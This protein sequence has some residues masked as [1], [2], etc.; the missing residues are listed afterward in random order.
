VC[1]IG[2]GDSTKTTVLDAIEFALAPRWSIPFSDADFYQAK[3][4]NP[5]CIEVTV[6][7]LPEELI[8]EDRYGLYLRG[9]RDNEPIHD[10][11]ED[12]WEPVITVCL[13]VG[14]DLE[15]RWEV[16][17]D[18][19]PDAKPIPWRDRERL[20]IARLGADVEKH[21]T[22]SRGSALSRITGDQTGTGATLA[23]ANRAAHEAIANASLVDLQ[24]A[25]EVA[26]KAALEFG[27]KFP[28]L[29]PGLDTQSFSV[30]SGA[31]ALQDAQGVPLRATGLGTRRLAALAVEQTG[32]GKDAIL[33]IDEI[34]S[35]LEPHR[36][37]RLLRKLSL[38]RSAS[39][40][41]N[42]TSEVH[43]Q[44]IMTTHS[45]TA[46][47]ALPVT[48]LAFV[49]SA[50]GTTTIERVAPAV[51]DTVQGI[52]RRLGHALLARKIIVCE[53]KTEE[54]LCRVMDDVYAERHQ[55][56][57]FACFGVVPVDGEGRTSGPQCALEF[58]RLGYG[59]AYFGDS[60]QPISP[61]R[62]ELESRGIHVVLWE[63]NAST[64]E[65]IALDLPWHDLQQLVD[66]AIDEHGEQ[67][68]L[69]AISQRLGPTI[70]ALGSSLNSWE[71]KGS[72]QEGIRRAIGKTA[73]SA[74]HGWFKDLNSGEVLGRIVFQALPRIPQ[75]PLASSLALIET[76]VYAE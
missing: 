6:G 71:A 38:D 65:R 22:W 70:V 62:Q 74:K 40:A 66:S 39:S 73:K 53:G 47:V 51:R 36:I 24:E 43:G 52:V 63:G 1:L 13:R 46:V 31:L 45:P 17:K 19:Q 23:I 34:E 5:I 54:A 69:S 44:V 56:Q 26:R 8:C 16:I 25:A 30:G 21:L 57:N 15:P 11:P 12:G 9:Y 29:R 33:L 64:E 42:G 49:Q 58:Q 32:L 37:R 3:T 41:R 76:W 50:N 61:D 20:C 60:D 67:P 59:V 55:G 4:D 68:V 48:N 10:D 7:E 14:A 72:S 35:A 18:S 27:V 28:A 75:T 2:P